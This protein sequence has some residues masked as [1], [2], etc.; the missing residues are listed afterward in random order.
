VAFVPGSFLYADGDGIVVAE[1]NLL[2]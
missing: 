1:R 2:A